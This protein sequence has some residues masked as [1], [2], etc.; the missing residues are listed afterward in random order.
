[1]STTGK[2]QKMTWRHIAFAIA[3]G[4][5]MG[6]GIGMLFNAAGVFY[7]QV[8]TD[9]G[10]INAETGKP[11]TGPVG[12]WVT[13]VFVGTTI[14]LPFCGR[15]LEKHSARVIYT[16]SI[17]CLGVAFLINAA[18]PGIW[19][20]YIAGVIGSVPSAFILYLIPVLVARWFTKKLGL[21]TGLIS[22]MSGIGAAIWNIVAANIISVSGWRMGYVF[23]ALA[24]LIVCLPLVVLFIRSNPEEVGI[25]PYGYSADE[26]AS[27]TN[28]A[29][30][31][32]KRR[33]S[34]K[35]VSF[36]RAL[37]SPAFYFFAIQGFAGGIFAGINQF[38]PT[39][40]NY[41]LAGDP[42]AIALI[43]ASMTSAT[44][45]SNLLGKVIFAALTDKSPLV[46]VLCG[47][48]VPAVSLIMLLFFAG[49]SSSA[50]FFIACGFIYGFCNPNA[51]LILPLC[52]RKAFGDKD[53]SEIWGAISPVAALAAG[54]GFTIWG[55]IAS[56]TSFNVVFA[57]GLGILV[58]LVV[59]YLAAR[60]NAKTLP[61]TTKAEDDQTAAQA[62]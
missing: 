49:P 58:L 52:V 19:A 22:G 46:A 24:T 48:G 37:K 33:L 18:A 28:D 40:A 59:C 7:P 31:S 35:G 30:A 20:F 41:T 54:F 4:A 6:V 51:V 25:M 3:A 1:M 11:N 50:V 8:A 38:I 34:I 47:A 2:T 42:A 16:V 36:K 23:Y 17:I 12:L 15:L 57:I 45:V 32:E 5:M 61:Q 27:A 60:A 21:I 10:M 29:E 56:A 13:I 39:Y 26:A 43:G 9:F 14:I 55:F 44:M 53:Y 62:A